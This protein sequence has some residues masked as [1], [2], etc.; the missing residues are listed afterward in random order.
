ML[1][2]L[3]QER[4][5]GHVV[6]ECRRDC[7][8][9]F[10]DKMAEERIVVN[11]YLIALLDPEV[12]DQAWSNSDFLSQNFHAQDDDISWFWKGVSCW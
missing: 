7:T 11:F 12:P 10:P 1:R 8:R 9:V 5:S 2:S 6:R 4:S 3:E